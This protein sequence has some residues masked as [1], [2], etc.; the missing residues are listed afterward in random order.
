MVTN[1]H[2]HC[3]GQIKFKYDLELATAVTL[4]G[5]RVASRYH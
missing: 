4:K 3:N 1:L 2:S 5:V